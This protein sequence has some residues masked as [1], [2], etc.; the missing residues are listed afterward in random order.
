[1][2]ISPDTL[3][4]GRYRIQR[5]L[6][7]GGMGAV[8]LAYDISLET[9]VAVKVN[10]SPTVEGATQFLGEARLLATLR[11]PNLPRVIDYFIE[12]QNQYLVMDFIPGEDL[13]KVIEVGGPQAADQVVAWAEQLGA[14]LSYLHRQKPP[15]FHRDI[16]PANLKLTDENEVVL[17]DFGIA[18]VAQADQQTAAGAAMY[19]PGYAPPEQY[20]R[21]H[22]GAYSDQYSLAATLYTLLTGASPADSVQR[23]LGLA[24]L[25]PIEQL[26]PAVPVNVQQAIEKAM[27]L[28]PD[29]RFG[30]VDDFVRALVDP[31]FRFAAVQSFATVPSQTPVTMPMVQSSPA[32]YSPTPSSQVPSVPVGYSQGPQVSVPPPRF[33]Q[34]PQPAP[35]AAPYG[36]YA[37]AAPA[38]VQK[39]RW[40]LLVAMGLIFLAAVSAVLYFGVLS[41]AAAPAPS[42]T[43]TVTNTNTAA[44]T[45]TTVPSNTPAFTATTAVTFTPLPSVTFTPAPSRT[46]PP[47]P[48]ATPVLIGKSRGIAYVS[49][50]ADGKTLQIWL[51]PVSFDPQGQVVS[52]EPVQLTGDAGDKH[53][54]AWSPDGSKLLYVANG[55]G[56]NGLDIFMLDLSVA[57][58]GPVNLTK[59]LGDDYD[60]AWSPDGKTIAFTSNNRGDKVPMIDLMDA[61]GSNIRRISFDLQEYNPTWAPDM[62]YILY[63]TYAND[64]YMLYWRDKAS[65]YAKNTNYDNKSFTGRTGQATE[66]AWS[67]DGNLIAYVRTDGVEKRIYLIV[68]TT[69][70]D[71]ITKLTDSRK[72]SAP[73]WSPD[74]QWIAFTT[75]RDGNSEIYIMN[76]QGQLQTNVTKRAG[77][78]LEPAWRP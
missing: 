67:P 6:G 31:T 60:P 50:R 10:H 44:A 52:G 18:K 1:M 40:G 28:K 27:S 53:Q 36:G 65:G 11:H 77:R 29:D 20:G 58:A 22:T 12:G 42:A 3:L 73:A 23:V 14:A 41:P 59:R 26:N 46:S 16:K 66:A 30:S 56:N 71:K 78:D 24:V 68:T 21:G 75:E 9:Q 49:D 25:T 76:S 63:T 51:L 57:N 54:P 74:S 62:G 33:T 7:R 37:P 48:T 39:T 69:R 45:S 43:P 32:S 8:Y 13:K 2:D 55:G 4:R 35:A 38:P 15:V 64:L 5:L 47:R 70:G 17:V 61:N 19:T 34:P 72:D